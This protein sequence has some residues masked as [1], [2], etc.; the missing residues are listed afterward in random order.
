MQLRSSSLRV[1]KRCS[2]LQSLYLCA[3]YLC[4]CREG[5]TG[6]QCRQRD[7]NRSLPAE[8][9]LFEVAM[10]SNQTAY[11]SK[12]QNLAEMHRKFLRFLRG[13]ISNPAI[14]ED[15]LQ[16]A[17]LKAI[18]HESGLRRD[19]SSV[20]WFY[21]ILRNAVIDYYRQSNT[22]SCA[23]DQFAAEWN[24]SYEMELQNRVCTCI[25]EV[26][27][28]LKPGYRSVIE[29]IDLGGESVEGFAASQQTTAGNAHVRLHRARK[30]IARKLIDVCGTCATYHC[31]DCTCKSNG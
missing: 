11:S 18:Q 19:E 24:E 4:P 23:V 14:A 28:E 21:R 6:E 17:Y 31:L 15:I 2:C 16:A 26:L 13:R 25:H 5:L 8:H 10:D 30:A 1:Q 29:R 22:R 12:T 7:V 3:L 9:Q 20:V 27:S